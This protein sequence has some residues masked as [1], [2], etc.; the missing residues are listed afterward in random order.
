[1]LDYGFAQLRSVTPAVDAPYTLPLIGGVEVTV[2]ISAEIPSFTLPK[3]DSVRAELA[4]AQPIWAPVQ[5]G[6]EVGELRF[7]NSEGTLLG[8]TPVT[9]RQS[10]AA[11]RQLPRYVWFCRYFG[12]LLGRLLG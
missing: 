12:R 1:L 3:W 9:V 5:A 8:A 4:V 11:R 6:E 10:V 2:G 7:Y